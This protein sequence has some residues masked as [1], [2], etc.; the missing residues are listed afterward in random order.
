[1]G[2]FILNLFTATETAKAEAVNPINYGTD[3]S[4]SLV[5]RALA[6]VTAPIDILASL[7]RKL[8]GR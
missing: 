5:E 1:M 3:G 6:V 2:L 8:E 7:V 4:V